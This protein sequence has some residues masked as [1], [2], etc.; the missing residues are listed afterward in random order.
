MKRSLCHKACLGSIDM[1][2]SL[3]RET[4]LSHQVRRLVIF[5]ASGC[6]IVCIPDLIDAM[7]YMVNERKDGKGSLA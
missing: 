2:G 4:S 7:V 3:M 1:H 5:Q 6:D